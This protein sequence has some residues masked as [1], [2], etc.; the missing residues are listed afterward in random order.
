MVEMYAVTYL[1]N[2]PSSI[3]CL[4]NPMIICNSYLPR[5]S[6]EVE[7]TLGNIKS[8]FVPEIRFFWIFIKYQT[9]FILYD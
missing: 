5:W 9:K 6:P 4:N 1:S 7:V 2:V 8:T 3:Y